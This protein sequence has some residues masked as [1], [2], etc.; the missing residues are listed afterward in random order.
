MRTST[1]S[2]TSGVE[3]DWFDESAGAT[4]GV[5]WRPTRRLG[6]DLGAGTR[7]E[8]LQAGIDLRFG[9]TTTMFRIRWD[10]FSSP[11]ASVGFQYR[12]F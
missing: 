1:R 11:A 10:E 8:V 4:A 12:R 5:N 6:L 9:A 3:A 2:G 7:Y